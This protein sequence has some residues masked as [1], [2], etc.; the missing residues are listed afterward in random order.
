MKR[1][2]YA[3]RLCGSQR[4]VDLRNDVALRKIRPSGVFAGKNFEHH[5]AS[6]HASELL[7]NHRDSHC[8]TNPRAIRSPAHPLATE[9]DY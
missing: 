7:Y 4:L 1:L 3:A 5:N 2:T 8:D 6:A 9:S